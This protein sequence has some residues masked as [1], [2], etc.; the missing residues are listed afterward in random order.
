MRLSHIRHFKSFIRLKPDETLAWRC[1]KVSYVCIWLYMGLFSLFAFSNPFVQEGLCRWLP[2]Q[3]I[4]LYPIKLVI[5]F[6]C[7]FFAVL[8]IF[9]V[10][11][12][13]T[14]TLLFV[15]SLII[16]SYEEANGQHFRSALFTILFFVQAVAYIFMQ[17]KNKYRLQ[18]SFQVIAA[19]YTLSG[20]SKLI[21]SGLG[22][23]SDAPYLLLQIKKEAFARYYTTGRIDWLSDKTYMTD[24]FAK[25][26]EV[27]SVLLAVVLLI[28]TCAFLILVN[29]KV[30]K[31]YGLLL[32]LVN[33][34]IFICLNIIIPA[35][36]VPALIF[37]LNPVYYF[38][39]LFRRMKNK[40]NKIT[41]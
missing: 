29:Q 6:S 36:A 24:F 39:L 37:L 21:T 30:A 15:L 31:V 19:V 28:E 8:Y 17:D 25:N 2:C 16:F 23:I 26:P 4:S 32:L 22:W 14:C 12:K 35:I 20:I 3:Y 9:E 10:S 27:L 38:I 34:G 7:L 13:T 5:A 33:I 1:I 11:M 18:F 40:T 41:G